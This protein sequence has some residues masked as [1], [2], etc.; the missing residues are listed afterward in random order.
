MSQRP[1]IQ[2]IRRLL[3]ERA[4]GAT[5]CP[6]EVARALDADNWR[7]H[8][9]AVRAAAV[10]LAEAGEVVILQRGHEVDAKRA[11]GPIRIG[12]GDRK[13]AA[14]VD[15]YRG[16]DFREHPELYRVGRGEQGVLVAEPYKSELLPLWRFKD[17]QTARGSAAALWKAFTAYRKSRD[18]VGMD[19]ARK[20]LQM[21]YTRARRY[22]NHRSGRKY[23]ARD[24]AK[25]RAARAT[26]PP[27]EDAEKARAAAIFLGYWQKAEKD[28]VYAAWRQSLREPPAAKPS[29]RQRP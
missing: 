3:R 5:L 6:S 29:R 19:M 27:T 10:E 28:R 23:A 17:E 4:A 7:Q 9:S 1:I 26:L 21:G 2:A 18:Y 22:A 20:F 15:T 12:H 8:M 14:Y 16:I 24:V 13:R 25:P 11:R